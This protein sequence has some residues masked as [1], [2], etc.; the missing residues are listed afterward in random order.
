MLSAADTGGT[1][2]DRLTP[3]QPLSSS[4]SLLCCFISCSP[5]CL[6]VSLSCI[7]FL[8]LNTYNDTGCPP[9]L[10]TPQ[11]FCTQQHH[12]TTCFSQASQCLPQYIS[13]SCFCLSYSSPC[14]LSVSIL[15]EHWSHAKSLKPV[16]LLLSEF[17]TGW[18]WSCCRI[19]VA[20]TKIQSDC[21]RENSTLPLQ[22]YR[23]DR[24]VQFS[25][26]PPVLM[27]YKLLWKIAKFI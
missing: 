14:C 27:E 15:H 18:F 1:W 9:F 2:I 4:F 12:D 10:Q 16:T 19:S 13:H 11:V 24:L 23:C 20:G 6:D 3:Q 17:Y 8:T 5:N 25:R 22:R 21:E 26:I 7:L